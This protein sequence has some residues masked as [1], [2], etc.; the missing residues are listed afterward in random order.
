MKNIIL[1]HWTGEMNELCLLSSKN[2]EKYAKK[3]GA[4]YQLLR[5][6]VFR[7]HLNSP[8]QKMYML[9]EVFDEYDI[10]VMMDPDMF[11]R[12]GMEE[13]I[14]TDVVGIGRHTAIQDQ[15]V[16]SL[17]RIY[18]KHGNPNYPYWGGS[19]YRLDRKLRKTLRKHINENE[20]N[21]FH[22]KFH[23]EGIMHRLA[24]LAKIE[25]TNETYLPGNHWNCGSFED[26]VKECAIIHIRTKVTPT[27]PKKPK[28]ENY[29]DLVKRGL[30]EE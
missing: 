24:V 27:G 14:F 25:T 8:C 2:I 28:I 10:V 7:E 19:I 26:E 12:K 30:I 15:L 29:R 3:V 4:D 11:T 20:L 17:S 16:R 1:Q 5:G 13:N 22:D 9:D 21:L 23:D 18:K 6:N